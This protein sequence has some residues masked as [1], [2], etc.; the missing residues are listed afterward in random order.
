[1][2]CLG[3]EGDDVGE[4][5]NN[6]ANVLWEGAVADVD[7]NEWRKGVVDFCREEARCCIIVLALM[8]DMME[9]DCGEAVTSGFGEKIHRVRIDESCLSYETS[10]RLP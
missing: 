2:D 6:E 10:E 3:K 9:L 5:D 8:R 1:M 4:A 7:S